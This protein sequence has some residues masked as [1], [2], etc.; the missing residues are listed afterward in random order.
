MVEAQS[1]FILSFLS[2]TQI[3]CLIFLDQFIVFFFYRFTNFF[4]I[5]TKNITL[6]SKFITMFLIF[7]YF[8]KNLKSQDQPENHH[9]RKK[10]RKKLNTSFNFYTYKKC[11]GKK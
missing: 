11:H 1:I 7:F 8:K 6:F 2:E 3:Q 5:S 10:E 4:G 9:E